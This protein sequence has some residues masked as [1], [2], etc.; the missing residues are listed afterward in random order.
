VAGR[1]VLADQIGVGGMGA[2]WR[3][4]DLRTG[5]W[6]AAKLLGRHD[7]GL[8]LRFVHEQSVRIRHPHVV[9]P[10]GWAAED[11]LVVLTMD[12]VR[13]GSLADLLHAHGRLPD[14]VVRVL[15]DQM[16]QALVAV[17]AAGVVHRDLKPANV[18][19]EATGAGRP[20][21][22]LADFGVAATAAEQR[23]HASGPIGTDG[24]MAPEQV[25]GD[26]PHPRQ[27]VY[28]AGVLAAEL[29]TGSPTQR[30][31]AGPLH[32][33]LHAMTEPDSRRRTPSAEVAL[34]QLRRLGVPAG[35]PP[36]VPPV[37]D[38]LGPPPPRWRR[39]RVR[40]RP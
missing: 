32:P 13:G 7:A 2:V 9:A 37:P 12:L 21:A 40:T 27:D 39:P 38:R 8:L 35:A 6:V 5:A 34:A 20:H 3:A 19:L 15:L 29:L 4:R 16:L 1:Y 30:P 11:H 33:L 17:H 10:S 36:G 24:Y 26:P 23:L 22:R 31:L 18:L 14:G 25:L 28:A